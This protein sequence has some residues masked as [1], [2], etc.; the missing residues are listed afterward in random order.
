[1]IS[2]E[3]YFLKYAFPC[4]FLKLERKE[5]TDKEYKELES[6][7]LE[8]DSVS[9]SKLEKIF[10]PAFI[11]IKRLAKKMNKDYWNFDVMKEYWLNEHNKLIEEN[12]GGYSEQT[13]KFKDLCRI[14]VAEIIEKDGNKFI[15]QYSNKKRRVYNSI[16]P[17]ADRGDRVTIH[18]KY[19]IEKL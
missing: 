14:H 11:R 7:F 17:E 10:K 8:G 1:M 13:E 19:A 9:R 3:K 15:V 5:I 6:K 12:D 4:A 16:L 18:F 2:S